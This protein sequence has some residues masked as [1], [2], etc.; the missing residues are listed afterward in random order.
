MPTSKFDIFKCCHFV[1]LKAQ[2]LIIDISAIGK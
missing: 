1:L 2:K